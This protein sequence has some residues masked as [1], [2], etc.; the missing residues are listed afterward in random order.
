MNVENNSP[1]GD[2]DVEDDVEVITNKYD[3]NEE[4]NSPP[5]VWKHKGDA[6]GSKAKKQKTS[7]V[8]SCLEILKMS[9]QTMT[10]ETK[11]NKYEKVSAILNSIDEIAELGEAFTF[12]CMQFLRQSDNAEYF[13]GLSSNKQRVMFLKT[14]I[15]FPLDINSYIPQ[16]ENNLL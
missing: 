1:I 8:D 16:F 7:D 6:A 14:S 12:Q 4:T 5:T 13:L 3:S 2:E 10:K 11:S 9:L 15:E